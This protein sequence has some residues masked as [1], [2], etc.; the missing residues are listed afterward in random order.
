M[1]LGGKLSKREHQIMDL[2]Y[3]R[4]TVT[5]SELEETLAG[6]PSNSAIRSYLRSLEVKGFLQH[7]EEGGRFVYRP[8]HDRDAVARVEASR[9]LKTFFGG[10]VSGMLAT[11]LSER[12]A[13][14]SD[15]E[16]DEMRRMVERAKE[17]N[18]P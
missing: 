8:I 1:K 6:A 18:Q 15:E 10:S 3:E 5:A 16:L 2:A 4:G 9:L 14:L 7:V 17:D 12:E 11:L 13:D